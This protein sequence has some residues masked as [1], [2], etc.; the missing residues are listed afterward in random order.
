MS[1]AS[2]PEALEALR[3]GR[4][5]IVADDEGRENE[6]DVILAAESAT[7]EWI[8]W[9][10]RHSSGFICAPM[11]NEIADRLALP[12]MVALN[13]DPRGTAYTVTVDAADRLSTGISAADRAHTLRVLADPASVPASLSR[14]GHI[15][16]LRAVDGGVRERDGHT[17]AAVDLMKLAGL[18][19]VGAISEIVADDGEMM[20]L[21]GLIAL[22]EREGVLVTTI[23]ALVAFL[24]ENP[25]A[26][27]V[28]AEE[29]AAQAAIPESSNVSFEVETTVPTTHGSFRLRAYRDRRTGADHVAIIA[30]D[31]QA[32]GA[33]VRVHS[34]CLTGEAFGSLKCECGPQ[35]DSALDTIQRHGGVVVYL[36]GHEGRGIGLVNK[37]RAYRLQ[38]DGLDTLDANLALGLPAD[39]RDY[40]AASAI[41]TDLGITSVRLL[42]NNPEKERQLTNHGIAVSERVPLVVGVGLFNE[43]YLETKRDRMG[44]SI[45]F[46]LAPE[47]HPHQ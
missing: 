19:P 22:G 3:Q 2:I 35:L 33:L 37:L 45:G 1:I 18:V 10:V 4:P 42:S 27:A 8:A 31:P 21:P 15:V 24:E 32:T 25:D 6:G 5:V 20:R 16:P 41:L 44:H 12:P 47:P 30:G 39:A 46:E 11:T 7:Q 23:A 40:T 38:E 9:T 17:E 43:G 29:R 14:P 36:R 28:C 26:A 34:E 13:E